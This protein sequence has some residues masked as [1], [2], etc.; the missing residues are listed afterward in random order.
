MLKI[1][2]KGRVCKIWKE[3]KITE[4]AEGPSIELDELV[5][6]KKKK[7]HSWAKKK[8]RETRMERSV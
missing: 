6:K 3:H 8:C 4:S 5:Q 7:S 2:S 1:R